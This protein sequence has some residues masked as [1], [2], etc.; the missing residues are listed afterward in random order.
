M[1]W[2]KFT[3]QFPLLRDFNNHSKAVADPVGKVWN[4]R[5]RS[6]T[7]KYATLERDFARLKG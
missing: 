5:V 3:A 2:C 4:G 6:Y 7:S 1:F